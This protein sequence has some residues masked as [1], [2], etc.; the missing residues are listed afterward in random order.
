MESGRA[1]RPEPP[2]PAQG[3]AGEKVRVE[4]WATLALCEHGS[5]CT[6]CCWLWQGRM[7]SGFG[8]LMV[9]GR[10]RLAHR[11]MW[12][13]T[14]G[15]PAPKGDLVVHHPTLCSSK[16]CCNPAHLI[17]RTESLRL[18]VRQSRAMGERSPHAKLTAAQVKMIRALYAAGGITQKR[19]GEMYGVGEA[20]I[21]HIVQRRSWKHV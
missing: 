21:G 7:S 14:N 5:P 1:K 18:R 17:L 15:Y 3:K 13:L 9:A 2:P 12:E 10:L 8:A 4:V 11:V 19:L 6:S 20:T 16:A